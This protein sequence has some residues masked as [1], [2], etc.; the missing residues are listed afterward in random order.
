[1]DTRSLVAF[2][3]R[4]VSTHLAQDWSYLLQINLPVSIASPIAPAPYLLHQSIERTLPI[5]QAA[6][7]KYCVRVFL[8][9]LPSSS[10]LQ[11]ASSFVPEGKAIITRQLWSV[12]TVIL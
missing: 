8:P 3:S 1:M 10:F 9:K 6:S 7:E 5:Q 12:L 2:L 11:S 4:F